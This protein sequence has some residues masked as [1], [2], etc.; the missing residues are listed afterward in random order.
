MEE[1]WWLRINL[2]NHLITELNL[3]TSSASVVRLSDTACP[4]NICP[5]PFVRMVICPKNFGQTTI[6]T[7]GLQTNGDE[8]YKIKKI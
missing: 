2:T 8:K 1:H 5:T 6:R 4:M 3:I 7:N